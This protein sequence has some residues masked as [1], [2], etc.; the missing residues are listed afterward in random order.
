MPDASFA[1]GHRRPPG[2]F[3]REKKSMKYFIQKKVKN[4]NT[5]RRSLKDLL[6]YDVG[7]I[8]ALLALNCRS[9]FF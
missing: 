4:K 2:A 1:R 9:S 5:I 7:G 3:F 6:I 8:I